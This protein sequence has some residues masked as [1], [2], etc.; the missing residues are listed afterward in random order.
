MGPI[1]SLQAKRPSVPFFSKSVVRS[2]IFKRCRQTQAHPARLTM[3]R[4]TR[5]GSRSM[6][7]ELFQHH[8]TAKWTARCHHFGNRLWCGDKLPL[9]GPGY[10]PAECV[11][12][13]LSGQ[14]LCVCCL[15]FLKSQVGI[16]R[17]LFC[18]QN[19][20][21]PPNG[22]ER[23]MARRRRKRQSSCRKNGS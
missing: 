18:W 21:T 6:D 7:M 1:Q 19:A 15:L 14:L 16:R 17:L 2:S 3:R 20:A 5:P 8:T 23:N 12:D 4:V 13:K 9:G 10:Q 11:H 22:L